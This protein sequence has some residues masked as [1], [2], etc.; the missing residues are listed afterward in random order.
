[1][2]SEE[3]HTGNTCAQKKLQTSA[4]RATIFASSRVSNLAL[5]VSMPEAMKSRKSED[6]TATIRDGGARWD[7]ATIWELQS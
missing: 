2:I 7:V 1:M 3:Q 5:R 6:R 4:A